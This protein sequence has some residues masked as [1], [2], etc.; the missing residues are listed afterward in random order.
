MAPTDD[1]EFLQRVLDISP[2]MIVVSW[3]DPD[4]PPLF[5]S[6]EFERATGFVVDPDD[7]G[8]REPYWDH[9]H[10][11][12]LDM[13]RAWRSSFSDEHGAPPPITY[14]FMTPTGWRW[15]STSMSLFQPAQDGEPAQIM[16]VT[17]DI[18]E[19]RRAQDEH[20]ETHRFYERVLGASSV[21]IAAVDGRTRK[22]IW[23]TPGM[24]RLLGMTAEE[25][26]DLPPEQRWELIHPDDRAAERARI[27][28]VRAGEIEDVGATHRLMTPDGWR[29]SRIEYTRLEPAD[30]PPLRL[31]QVTDV[32]DQTVAGRRPFGAIHRRKTPRVQHGYHPWGIHQTQE[33]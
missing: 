28:A 20:E 9:L 15:F 33:N 18:T 27:A 21:M 31:E 4:R 1:I 16:L 6:K 10:P 11:D 5:V 19:L 29:W 12:D 24:E 25:F 26:N 14:R 32:H 23:A 7:D 22:R 2:M 13:Q 8:W 17:A 30:G 3:A